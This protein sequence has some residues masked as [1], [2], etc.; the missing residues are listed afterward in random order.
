MNKFKEIQISC[1]STYI[2]N[3]ENKTKFRPIGRKQMVVSRNKGVKDGKVGERIK[4]YKS[5]VINEL[6]G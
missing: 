1:D 5:A 6:W 4:K 3:I 2:W